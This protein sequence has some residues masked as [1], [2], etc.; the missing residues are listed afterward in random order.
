MNLPTDSYQED[1][2]DKDPQYLTPGS[3]PQA[4]P[5]GMTEEPVSAQIIDAISDNKIP[6]TG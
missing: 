5:S 2:L 6:Y 1:S 3:N 4:D